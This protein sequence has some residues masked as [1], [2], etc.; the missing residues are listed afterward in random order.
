MF[1][2]GPTYE[3]QIIIALRAAAKSGGRRAVILFRTTSMAEARP[4]S[5]AIG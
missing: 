2:P 3:Q 4:V 1:I 5:Y